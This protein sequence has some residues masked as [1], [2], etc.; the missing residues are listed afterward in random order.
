M[1]NGKLVVGLL[2]V[3][4]LVFACPAGA[5]CVVPVDDLY[6][7]EDTVLCPGVYTINDVNND[8]V[9]IIKRDNVNVVC[10][11]TVVKSSPDVIFDDQRKGIVDRTYQGVTVKDCVFSGFVYGAFFDSTVQVNLVNNT[12]ENSIGWGYGAGIYFSGVTHSVVSDNKVTNNSNGV[13]FENS[14]GNSLSNNFICFNTVDISSSG[15]LNDGISNTCDHTRGDWADE[16]TPDG[17]LNLCP[18]NTGDKDRD[19]VING[20][21]NCWEEPNDDQADEGDH[22]CLFFSKPYRSDPH[23]GDACDNCPQEANSQEDEDS[24]DVGDACDY[25]AHT[26]PFTSVDSYGCQLCIDSDAGKVYHEKGFV[27]PQFPGAPQFFDY[28]KDSQVLVE[29]YCNGD[30]SS[31]E[32]YDCRVHQNP[33]DPPSSCVDGAC[34]FDL[35]IDGICDLN[36][37]DI[38]GDGCLNADDPA[39][40]IWSPDPD[41]DKIG[42]D[43]D[44][45]RDGDFCPNERDPKPDFN[46]GNSDNDIWGDDCDNCPTVG[47]FFQ[48][49]HD[50]DPFGDACDDDDDNDGC[51]D[52]DD[53]FRIDWHPNSDSTPSIF[54]D[55]A[56]D[57]D[58]CPSV[59]NQ[60][61]L[62]RDT[63]GEGDACDC[64]DG[65]MGENE[66]GADCGNICG[67]S[68][69]DK[70]FA[71]SQ[72]EWRHIHQVHDSMCMPVLINGDSNGKIDIVFMMAQDY[73][74]DSTKFRADIRDMI[75]NAFL[76]PVINQHK[77]KINFWYLH[78]PDTATLTIDSQTNCWV[79]L[80]VIAPETHGKLFSEICPM[81]SLAAILHPTSCRD[82]AQPGVFA[83]ITN[84]EYG[85]LLHEAGHGVFGL[86]DEYDDSKNNPPCG[87]SYK[88]HEPFPNVFSSKEDCMLKTQFPPKNC[89]QYTTCEGGRWRGT[90]DNTMMWSCY[91][92]GVCNWEDDA[93]W[94]VRSVFSLYSDP[95]A[96]ETRKALVETFSY[97]GTSLVLESSHAV[98]GDVPERILE[99]DGLRLVSRDAGGATVG[100]FTIND[101]RY[102]DYVNP[103]GGELLD[104]TT[105]SVVLFFA[106]NIKSLEVQ[107]I[108]A[109]NRVLGVFDLEPAVRDFC[110]DYPDDP[111]CMTYDGDNDG[112]PDQQDKCPGT[113]LPEVFLKLNPNHHG[114]VDGDRVFEVG[115]AKGYTDST[116]TITKTSGCGCQQILTQKPGNN[117]GE[118]KHGCTKGTMDNFIKKNK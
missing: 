52:T 114:D 75:T 48:D 60:D 73:G 58:N 118:K 1:V 20:N 63:D 66:Q 80:P 70:Y 104:E 87:T 68:C 92:P 94:K 46:S 102:V 50:P 99:W 14:L 4:V 112:I 61:Q 16:G 17:C 101:P 10:D 43:C 36:D 29:N 13:I 22:D 62:D 107:D 33:G 110:A 81:G 93:E 88:I 39:S 24:D 113:V 77:N 25:C 53:K 67:I 105:F 51:L 45:D 31:T 35:D 3:F 15:S 89:N 59:L 47:N 71:T 37:P 64:D 79:S 55:F 91:T 26:P 7:T 49:N 40:R 19:G 84:P 6:I 65:W 32:E 108:Q 97:D 44:T 8:G 27:G 78:S 98:Y 103:P 9:I 117:E 74:S 11:N 96:E 72:G 18:I 38:D 95:P 2:C 86:T 21:D 69:F 41:N 28:C 90:Y 42:N 30:V 85:I 116:Y 12:F 100:S 106:D 109:G 83:T 76:D 56:D 5:A 54:D 82:Y 23:C 34:C 57:C 111:Q 115:S